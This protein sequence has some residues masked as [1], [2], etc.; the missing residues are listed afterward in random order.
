MQ[1]L[2]TSPIRTARVKKGMTQTE[3]GLRLGVTKGAVS[4]WENG[5]DCPDVR[6]LAGMVKALRP[7]LD[8]GL[9]VTHVAAAEKAR[10]A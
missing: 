5:R 6:R 9:Y 4:A 8:V 1:P 2:N 10:A 7:H 3:L